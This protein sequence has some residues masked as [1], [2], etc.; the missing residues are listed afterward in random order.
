MLVIGELA[1]L[2][3]TFA[4]ATARKTNDAIELRN[5]V[6]KAIAQTF[7]LT[8]ASPST[9]LS[10]AATAPTSRFADMLPTDAG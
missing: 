4:M 2:S 6:E 10:N 9:S 3:A 8:R 1:A 7:P 5:T